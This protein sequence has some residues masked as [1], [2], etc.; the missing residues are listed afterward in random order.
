[1]LWHDSNNISRKI[2]NW[3]H[4]IKTQYRIYKINRQKDLRKAG[5]KQF[6]KRFEI[7]DIENRSTDKIVRIYSFVW[8][9][10]IEGLDIAEFHRLV[11]YIIKK[12][13][14]KRFPLTNFGEPSTLK[15]RPEY[16]FG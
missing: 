14:R 4:I 7:K 2:A 16:I 13:R 3:T 12:L 15:Y 9:K 8:I 10:D 6:S 11:R 5:F 1:M